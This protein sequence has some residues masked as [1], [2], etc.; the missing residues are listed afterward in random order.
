MNLIISP[1][2]ALDFAAQVRWL[3]EHS[4]EAGRNAATRIVEVIDLLAD[5]P[6]TSASKSAPRSAKNTSNLDAMD[7]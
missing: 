1:R 5:S 4:P 7:S 6:P 3:H 2:A